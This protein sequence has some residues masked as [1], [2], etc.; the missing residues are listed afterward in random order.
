MDC[1]S[2]KRVWSGVRLKRLACASMLLDHIGASCVEVGLL[3]GK[4]AG[5]G[6]PLFA[7]DL[8]LRCAGRPAFPIYCFL[9]VEGFEHTRDVKRYALRLLGFAL[10]SE[11]PF[12][13][14]FYRTPFYWE[15]QNVYWT[16]ALGVAAMAFMS[17][18]SAGGEPR[19][20]G[21]LGAAVCAAAAQALRSDYG[22]A[23]VILIVVLWALRSD[24]KN[25][26]AAGAVLTLYE[27]PAPLTFLLLW[28]YSGERG[29]CGE[30]QKWAYYLFYPAHLVILA[31]VT[32][33]II[34]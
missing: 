23:G 31:V 26:C 33:I 27:P 22:A 24:R 2:D 29:Q 13:L 6:S 21:L 28:R 1:S 32:N 12:D 20:Q 15:Y 16:L 14:A 19:W 11:A 34:G 18:Y 17:R 3:G 4:M 8:L 25:Q 10:V 7:L 9:L 30:A 5:V